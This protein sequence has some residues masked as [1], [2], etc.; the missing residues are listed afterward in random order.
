M[1]YRNSEGKGECIYMIGLEDS[2]NGLGINKWK[3]KESLETIVR[4]TNEVD[5]WAILIDVKKG[6]EG[7]IFILRIKRREIIKIDINI[8]ILMMG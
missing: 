2:G 3:M 8:K 1:K 7:L 6:W 4:M 5:L